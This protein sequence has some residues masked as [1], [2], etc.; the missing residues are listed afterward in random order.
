M[1]AKYYVTLTQYGAEQIAQIHEQNSISLTHMVVGDANGVPYN[2]IDRQDLTELIHQKAQFPI[3]SIEVMENVTRVTATLDAH[4]GG[5]HIHEIGLIDSRGKLVY[6]GNYHGAY[7]PIIADGGGGELEIVIDIKVNANAN[8]IIQIDPNIVTAN[9]NW[10]LEKFNELKEFVNNKQDIKVGDLFLT[11]QDFENSA[12]V[13]MHKGYGTWLRVGDGHALVTQASSA[14]NLA[15]TFMKTL[16]AMGGSNTQ[17][18]TIDHLPAHDHDFVDGWPGSASS[19]TAL[20]ENSI[21]IG[22]SDGYANDD[23]RDSMLLRTTR[24]TGAN[25]SLS[26]VQ[27]SLVIAVWQRLPEGASAPT[28]NLTANKSAIDEGEQVIFTLMTTGLAAGTLVDWTM[29]GIQS[30]DIHPAALTGQFVVGA[31]GT[32]TYSMNAVE[33]QKTEGNETLKF[34]LTYIPNK[35]VNVLIMDTSK[36]PEGLQTYYQ[37]THI[38]EVQPNQS[39]S[40]DMYGAGGGGGGSVYTPVSVDPNGTNGGNTVLSYLANTLTA[41]GGDGGIGGWWGNGSHMTDGTAGIGGQNTIDAAPSFEIEINQIGNDAVIGSISSPQ[42]GGAAI[43]SSIGAL[44]GGGNGAIG[45][46]QN[47]N[48]FGGG[49]GSGG[50]LKV[51]FT[52]TTE[53]PMVF[54]LAVGAAGQGWKTGGNS[55]T[56]GGIAFAII[57]SLNTE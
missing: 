27:N 22:N 36:Y 10:V 16:A 5:F 20:P 12:A 44:N 46:G 37:G 33:D 50:R 24:K 34:A 42:L 30:N 8:V 53:E 17:I 35:S 15:P 54:N 28:Y 4:M 55:G 56:D 38:I 19:S 45:I 39:I 31:D 11:M 9:K 41:G 26:I 7:K 29:T 47:G 13:A 23:E 1:T 14:N 51:K 32:A 52:N 57:E 48:S 6:L 49:G 25:E 3:Q 18:L 2:P 40:V 43:V 21:K